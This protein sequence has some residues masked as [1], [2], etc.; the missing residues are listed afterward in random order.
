MSGWQACA[1][2]WPPPAPASGRDPS[3]L[4]DTVGVTV[5]YPTEPGADTSPGPS[6]TGTPDEIAA[7]LRAHV[8]AGAEHLI[9]SLDPCTEKTVAEFAEAVALFRAAP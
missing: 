4:T 1:G 2:S 9:A 6:L 5:R 8:E 3:T 7:G